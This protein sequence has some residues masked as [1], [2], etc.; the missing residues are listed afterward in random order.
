MSESETDETHE[1]HPRHVP[2]EVP[3]EVYEHDLET[4]SKLDSSFGRSVLFGYIGGVVGIFLFILVTLFAVAPDIP[5]QA[6]FG[7]AAGVAFWIGILGGVFAVGAWSAKHES[8]IF[9]G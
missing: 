1:A 3:G 5:T 2:F 4:F 9:H 6:K 7:A 8:E